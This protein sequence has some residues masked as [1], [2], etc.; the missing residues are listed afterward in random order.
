MNIEYDDW[1]EK[2]KPLMGEDETPIKFDWASKFEHEM[3]LTLARAHPLHVWT[4]VDTE[5]DDGRTVILEG[6]HYV[7]R[8]AYYITVEPYV[9]G[10]QI[11]VIDF[12]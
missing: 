2:Y 11:G 5:R 10:E 1:L 8:V 12:D 3:M 9:E 6:W 7:N 4:E